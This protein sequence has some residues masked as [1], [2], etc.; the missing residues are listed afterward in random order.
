MSLW[1]CSQHGLTGPMP[2]C[3][4]A[5]LARIDNAGARSS[6]VSTLNPCKNVCSLI[7]VDDDHWKCNECNALFAF[8]GISKSETDLSEGK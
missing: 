2:C 1:H 8:I 7:S 3:P 4:G 6:V 5:S